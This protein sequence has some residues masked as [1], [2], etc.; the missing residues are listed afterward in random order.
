MAFLALFVRFQRKQIFYLVTFSPGRDLNIFVVGKH[1][2][3][4]K[5]N[6]TSF[7]KFQ[8]LSSWCVK[9][10]NQRNRSNYE[11]RKQSSGKHFRVTIQCDCFSCSKTSGTWPQ[12][13]QWQR[14]LLPN[15][16][17]IFC[18]QHKMLYQNIALSLKNNQIVL[19]CLTLQRDISIKPT[20]SGG[21]LIKPIDDEKK[22]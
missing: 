2:G 19:K 4:R 14:A 10:H 15:D 1:L 22:F 6:I 3:Y 13:S 20:E 21:L 7:Q 16:H 5:A 9:Y 18:F 12:R 17:E 8:S 11:L